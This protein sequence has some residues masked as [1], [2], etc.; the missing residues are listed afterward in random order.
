M[1]DDE[2]G[3]VLVLQQAEEGSWAAGKVRR[4]KDGGGGGGGG[5]GGGLGRGSHSGG[6]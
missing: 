4:V 1:L 5:L 6:A 3:K 2:S